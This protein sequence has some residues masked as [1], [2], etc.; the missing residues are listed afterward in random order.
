M[1]SVQL[2]RL[3]EAVLSSIGPDT[4]TDEDIDKLGFFFPST[5]VV[6]ALD[7][8]DRDCVIKYNTLWGRS[9]YQVLGSMG[10]YVVFPS[11]AQSPSMPS[12]CDCPAFSYTVLLSHTHLM[13]KHVLAARVAER[14][15]RCV[16]RS[17]GP[18]E[19]G[20]LLSRQHSNM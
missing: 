8:I 14:L 13:C 7:L 16:E 10:T 2:Y 17:I 5:L 12:F 3:L 4:L 20:S 11:L 1:A 15:R 9:H 18:D 6:G 19:L